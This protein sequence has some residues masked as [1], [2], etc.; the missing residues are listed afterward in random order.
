M[1]R[2]FILAGALAGFLGVGAGAFGA[3]ALRS[4]LEPR[5]FEVY[6][7]AVRYQLIHALA[8]LAAAWVLSRSPGLWARSSGGLFLL[9]IVLF[10]GSL[11]VVSLAG[12]KAAGVLTPLGGAAF[13]AGWLCLGVA[14][15]KSP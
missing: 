1:E 6:E 8:L 4:R 12:I 2:V 13:L 5:A 11:Y 7:V 3:H 10:S 9:G 14:G 15:W